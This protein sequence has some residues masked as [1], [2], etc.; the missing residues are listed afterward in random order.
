M[1]A[2][3]SRVDVLA[4]GTST[5]GPN[6][7]AELLPAIPANFPV[8]I[9]IVQQMPPLF[10]RLLAGRLNQRS[11]L[12]VREGVDG[13]ILKAGDAWIAPGDFHMTVEK[14]GAAMVLALN[15]SPPENYCRPAVD[16]LF[17][18]VAKLFGASALAVVLAGMG[19]DGSGGAHDIRQNGG[20]VLVQDQGSSIVWGMPGQIVAAGLAD[21]TYA[22]GSMA[23]E[24]CRRV[25]I[26]RGSPGGAARVGAAETKKIAVP[27]RP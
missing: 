24:I 1:K 26:K 7:L 15:R 22:L 27:Q 23:G 9:V 12:T 2:G 3:I 14:K 5:G 17:R 13:E 18:S 19:S 11:A 10:T 8:P 20:Q 21:A 6:A 16:P 25:A 4:I